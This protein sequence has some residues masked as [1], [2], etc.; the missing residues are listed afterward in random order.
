MSAGNGYI[1][2]RAQKVTPVKLL[3]PARHLPFLK[4]NFFF[5]FAISYLTFPCKLIYLGIYP[6]A[7][8]TQIVLITSGQTY[9]SCV[10]IPSEVLLWGLRGHACAFLSHRSGRE[11]HL[12]LQPSHCSMLSAEHPDHFPSSQLSASHRWVRVSHCTLTFTNNIG[13]NILATAKAK[14][15]EGPS[16]GIWM[17]L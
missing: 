7:F 1:W 8:Y 5:S 10:R 16:W 4:K 13:V 15:K 17:L 14:F 6:I 2:Q 3:S 12:W 11:C 9:H